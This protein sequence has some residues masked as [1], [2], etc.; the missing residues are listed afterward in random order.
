M[1]YRVELSRPA[2]KELAALP[3]QER[4]RLLKAIQS[5]TNDPRP[6]GTKALQGAYR[7]FHRLRVGNFRVIYQIHDQTVLVQ[8]IRIASRGKVYRNLPRPS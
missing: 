5:L 8:I 2:R 6:H 3:H 1:K 4:F 7:L